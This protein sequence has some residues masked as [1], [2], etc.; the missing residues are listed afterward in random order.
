MAIRVKELTEEQL[1]RRRAYDRKWKADHPTKL[2]AEQ[3]AR[4]SEASRRWYVKN[5][6]RKRATDR[7]WSAN[8]QERKRELDRQRRAENP[9]KAREYC[10][11]YRAKNQEKIRARRHANREEINKRQNSRAAAK[12]S[13]N[14]RVKLTEEQK[15]EKER[16]YARK[17]YYENLDESRRRGREWRAKH[18]ESR[19][20]WHKK[21]PSA[22]RLYYHKRRARL[23]DSFSPGVT[24][25]EWSAIC[26]RFTVFGVTLCAYCPRPGTTIDHVI[27]I[28]R[29]GRDEPANVVPCCV[30][31]NSSKCDKLLD[32]WRPREERRAV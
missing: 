11:K 19:R 20:K 7:L 2:T 27:P 18:P 23:H 26:K 29:G 28:A 1:A 22:K 5:K 32:E 30:S 9:E 21:N 8:N 4:K 6:E 3:R 15:R 12:R 16:E 31:C 13:A 17:K 24:P 14:V 10:R 25:A